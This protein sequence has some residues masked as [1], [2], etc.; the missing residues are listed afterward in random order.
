[1]GLETR[2]RGGV[3][4]YRKRRIGDKVISEYMGSGDL[5]FLAGIYDERE[6]AEREAKRQQLRQL[7]TEATNTDRMLAE[8][9]GIVDTFVS[10]S[11]IVEGYHQHKGQWR[12]KRGK[13]KEQT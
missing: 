8:L 5:A 2:E 4:Y 12:R 3:Y 7:R 6:R 11:L 10:A 9:A 1:M 13:S